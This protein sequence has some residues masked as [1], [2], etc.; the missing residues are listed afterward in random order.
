[1]LT[2]QIP[3]SNDIVLL[4]NLP[5]LMGVTTYSPHIVHCPNLAF[6]PWM[7][8]ALVNSNF[9]IAESICD[10]A[11]KTAVI[12]TFISICANLVWTNQQTS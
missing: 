2:D 5:K 10:L 3:P 7:R 1:M 8:T 12:S 11:P 6:N 9:L 4:T